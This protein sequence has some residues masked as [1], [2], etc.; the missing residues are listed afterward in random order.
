MKRY[1]KNH[2]L[3]L[4]RCKMLV[5]YHIMKNFTTMKSLDKIVFLKIVIMNKKLERTAMFSL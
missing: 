3:L 2:K 1:C 5:I 4:Y